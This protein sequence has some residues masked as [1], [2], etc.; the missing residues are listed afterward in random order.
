L[1]TGNYPAANDW[2]SLDIDMPDSTVDGLG[3]LVT[4]NTV[5]KLMWYGL[6]VGNHVYP[7]GLK[8]ITLATQ[9]IPANPAGRYVCIIDGTATN[10]EKV[11]CET[12]CGAKFTGSGQQ[13]CF[14]NK[15]NI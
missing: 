10:L 11:L 3:E 13:Y 2:D 12:L 7:K 6:F 15:W 1:E 9:F 5:S 4:K 8:G 14:F